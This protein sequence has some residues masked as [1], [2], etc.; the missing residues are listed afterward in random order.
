MRKSMKLWGKH[1]HESLKA[2]LEEGTSSSMIEQNFD[3]SLYLQVIRELMELYYKQLEVRMI[4]DTIGSYQ[5]EKFDDAVE[6]INEVDKFTKNINLEKPDNFLGCHNMLLRIRKIRASA[7]NFTFQDV[8]S[9]SMATLPLREKCYCEI[10]SLIKIHCSMLVIAKFTPESGPER[11]AEVGN[12]LEEIKV[13][14]EEENPE[15][16]SDWY[17]D[18]LAETRTLIAKYD[19]F[20]LQSQ[21]VR[22]SSIALLSLHEELRCEIRS[23][24]SVKC[25]DLMAVESISTNDDLEEDKVDKELHQERI[26][27]VN[28]FLTMIKLELEKKIPEKNSDWYSKKI[29]ETRKLIA[30]NF[31]AFIFLSQDLGSSSITIPTV[32]SKAPPADDV[33]YTKEQY[34]TSSLQHLRLEE[35]TS[36]STM[37]QNFNPLYLQTTREW[38]ELLLKQAEERR[39]D[40]ILG[41]YQRRYQ[42]E[43]FYELMEWMDEV[44]KFI[45][46]TSPEMSD[47]SFET[48][49]DWCKN[50]IARIRKLRAKHGPNLTFQ[51]VSDVGSSSINMPTMEQLSLREE[52][53]CEITSLIQINFTQSKF[54]NNLHGLIDEVDEFLTGIKRQLGK[55]P[56]TNSNWC[57]N[58]IAETKTLIAKW[59]PAFSLQSPNV[60]SSPIA[61]LSLHEELRCEI[62]SLITMKLVDYLLVDHSTP[63]YL[64]KYEK[65]LQEQ[66]NEVNKFLMEINL[67]LEEKI[68]EK[69][70]DWYCKKITE[71]RTLIAKRYSAIPL[72]LPQDVEYTKESYHVFLSFR[73]EDTRYGFTRN[74]YDALQ[75]E[76]FKTFMDDEGLQRGDSISQVLMRAIENSKLS[77]IVFSENYADSSWCLE[78]VVKILECKQKNDQLV[79]PIFYKVE[80]SDVRHQRNSYE[81]AMIKQET[82]YGKDSEKVKK[83]RSSLSQVCDLKAFHYKE[84]SGYERAFIQDIIKDV[85]NIRD[86]L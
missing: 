49:S 63:D 47:K 83:W 42:N 5:N 39:I 28:E 77:I 22:S 18:K 26:N 82:R 60:R 23:L 12:F 14:L 48:N 4:A 67:Q 45:S 56:E 36:I 25:A 59:E 53:C 61:L 34:L 69:N 32:E 68:L 66:T 55:R 51:R 74:L 65:A 24:I 41:S 3:P 21:D 35:G 7:P 10:S 64:D 17:Y 81:K 19:L 13:Q 9:S 79:W 46:E 8:R 75:K 72:V 40:E 1:I 84:N 15:M 6:W 43:K 78:E 11:I 27:E 2:K 30:K 58:M 52:L 33:G 50:T 80:P 20:S 73:G 44:D 31:P 38:L 70:S 85:M 86:R 71:T 16:N 76:R 29:A 54:S 62:R 57:F 37:E